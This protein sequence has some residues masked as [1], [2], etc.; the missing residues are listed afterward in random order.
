MPEHVERVRREGL[1]LSS[2]EG[3]TV[4]RPTIL[5]LFEVQTLF[6]S[7]LDVVFLC[8]TSYD[9]DWVTAM[10]APYLAPSGFV[11]PMQNG[12]NEERIAAQVGESARWASC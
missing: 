1:R 11:V 9:T 6:R 4:V 5:H 2:T 12:M 10:I 3:E 8:V 7:P